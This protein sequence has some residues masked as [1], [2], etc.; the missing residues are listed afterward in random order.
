MNEIIQGLNISLVGLLVTF[1]ALGLFILMILLLE[2]IFPARP[3]VI[4]ERTPS[5]EASNLQILGEDA[6]GNVDPAT[7]AAI[8]AA[9]CYFQ[10]QARPALGAR[11][12]E[13]HGR[14][15]TANK[16]KEKR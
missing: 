7:A 1:T 5:E 4:E 3:Q 12:V 16:T 6:S 10:M 13:G 8:M 14:W 15:W 11:L 9:I 2:K